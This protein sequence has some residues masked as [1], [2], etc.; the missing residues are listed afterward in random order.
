VAG[1]LVAGILICACA[2]FLG[3]RYAEEGAGQSSDAQPLGESALMADT[4]FPAPKG[5]EMV[6]TFDPNSG[7][8]IKVGWVKVLDREAHDS[9]IKTQVEERILVSP[10]ATGQ[11]LR[12]LLRFQYGQVKKQTFSNGHRKHPNSIYIYAHY[13]DNWKTNRLGWAGMISKPA[14]SKEPGIQLAKDLPDMDQMAFDERVQMACPVTKA[15]CTADSSKHAVRITGTVDTDKKSEWFKLFFSMEW[16][17]FRLPDLTEL[18]FELTHKDKPAITL[19]VDRSTWESIDNPVQD[20]RIAKKEEQL[21]KRLDKGRLSDDAFEKQ[22][23]SSS[24]KNYRARLKK[25]PD[26]QVTSQYRP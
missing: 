14:A 1:I 26:A 23:A 25:I 22:M 19:T 11:R 17:F 12:Q 6:T 18:T 21:L 5:A 16:L 4:R 7:E 3:S 24:L 20:G 9:P 2:G 13:R 15:H 10:D 8:W